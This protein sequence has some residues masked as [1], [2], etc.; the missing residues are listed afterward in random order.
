[1][2]TSLQNPLVKQMRKLQR[3]K[4]R[5]Q[6]GVFLLE[7]THLLQ[8]A[9]VVNWPLEVACCTSIWTEKYPLLWQQLQ[10]QVRAELVSTEVLGAMATTNTPDGVIAIATSKTTTPPDITN[11][12]L[13]LETIQD[14]GNLGTMI[15][16][17]AA[18]G[19]EGILLS[20]DTVDPEH[21]KVLRASAGTWFHIKIGV[22]EDLRHDLQ[23]YQQQGMQLLGTRLD[24]EQSYWD[25]NLQ[26]PTLILI[27][28]EGAGLSASLSE[29][30]DTQ[31]KIPT[32][33]VVESLNAGVAAA[34]LL[35]EAQ[36]QRI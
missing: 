4:Y 5:K 6:Q 24:A 30:A 21:P 13:V 1:M 28:N 25:C 8:E 20:A 11:L 14:P 17:A 10:A 33:P 34:L 19:A 35:Y 29:L 23:R 36:R 22:C 7:G 12:G 9:M 2:L 3:A 26:Q 18:A 32:A 15:R 27:G 31:V 16:T